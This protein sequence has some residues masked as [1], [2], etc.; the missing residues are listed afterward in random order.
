MGDLIGQMLNYL[1][2]LPEKALSGDMFA[3]MVSLIIIYSLVYIFVKSAKVLKNLLKKLV[4]FLIIA[5]AVYIFVMD[6]VFKVL[7]YGLTPDIVVFGFTGLLCGL[8]ALLVAFLKMGSALKKRSTEKRKLK[9]DAQL[10]QQPSS[11]SYG[12]NNIPPVTTSAQQVPFQSPYIPQQ[13]TNFAKDNS[14][15]MVII[16]LIVAEFG[17]FSSNTIAAVNEDTGFAF[18]LIFMLAAFIFIKLTY[19]NYKTGIKHLLVAFF[20]GYSLSLIL[21]Y[22]WGGISPDVLF[23][24]A[25]FAT[26]A[27]VALISGLSLSLFMSGKG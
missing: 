20:L 7:T 12:Q 13:I 18:F 27:L 22:F 16:Y 10:N 8:F 23:S 5:L 6:F 25:Y 26:D 19:N 21:G 17:I 11:T 4:L 3:I 2:E 9:M 1:L 24:K 14:I 15:G